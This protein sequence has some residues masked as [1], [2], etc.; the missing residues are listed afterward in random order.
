[1]KEINYTCRQM[2]ARGRQGRG[3]NINGHA[4]LSRNAHMHNVQSS[5]AEITAGASAAL[6]CMRMA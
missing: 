6:V 2:V 3:I 4:P 5:P 1:M